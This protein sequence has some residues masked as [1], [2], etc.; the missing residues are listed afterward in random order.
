[1][2]YVLDAS[3]VL[4][5]LK[6]EPG[7]ERVA[8]LMAGGDCIICAV[9][10]AETASKLA[11]SGQPVPAVKATLAALSAT[12]IPFDAAHATECGLL[13][14]VTRH[15]GLSLGDRACLALARLTNGTAIT[16]DRPWLQLAEPLGIAIECIRPAP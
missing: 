14:P 16:A 7:H 9:N 8:T 2:T 3:A 15:L 4:A 11:D 10:W 1:M 5:L 6:I 12:V 13:R